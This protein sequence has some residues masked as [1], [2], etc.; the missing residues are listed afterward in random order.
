MAHCAKYHASFEISVSL[1][2][3]AMTRPWQNPARGNLGSP[4]TS[5]VASL[6][7]IGQ[8]THA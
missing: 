2:D 8:T 4:A 5:T 3:D 7:L 1:G 6:H